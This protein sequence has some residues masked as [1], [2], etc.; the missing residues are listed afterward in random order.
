MA[1]LALFY[2]HLAVYGPTSLSQWLVYTILLPLGWLYG[3]LMQLRALMYRIGI[4]ASYRA[5]VPVISI[6]NLSVGGTGKTPVVDHLIRYCLSLDKRVAVVS[7]GYASGNESALRIVSAG[8]GPL[9]DVA[10]AGD[11]PWL[12]A[13]RNPAACVVVAPRR[14]MGVRHAIEVLGADVVLLDDGFQHL[15]VARDFDLVLLDAQRPF[16]NGKVLPAGL[17][18]EPRS[19]LKRGQLFLLTRCPEV[20]LNVPT[21]PGPVLHC[22]HEVADQVESID[23]EIRVMA[24]LA[25]L[26]GIAFAGIAEPESFFRSLEKRGLNLVQTLCFSDHASYDEQNLFRLIEAAGSADYF[27]TTEKDSVKLLSAVLPLPCF[28]VALR[29]VF[30]QPG[31]LE[32]RIFPVLEGDR[33]G[34]LSGTA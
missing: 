10:Q 5:S 16:G 26:R 34:D 20:N 8:Q 6:G 27:I 3:G 30:L 21:L 11:E 18:R 25:H 4:F 29:L 32:T 15:A 14:V 22:R 24:D 19:A 9:L 31:E 1:R 23:G 12:L 7:R 33:N 28:Q 17:L 13:R 2:R